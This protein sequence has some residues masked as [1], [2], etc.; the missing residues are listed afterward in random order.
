MNIFT[1]ES[2]AKSYDAYYK[3]EQGKKVDKIEKSMLLAHLR[4]IPVHPMLEIGCGTG[5]WTRFFAEHGFEVLAT[6]ISKAMLKIAEQ[7]KPKNVT[8]HKANAE[9]LPFDDHTFS[10]L[11]TIT[12]LEFV[13]DKQKALEEI[14]RVLKP[15]GWLLL[16]SLNALSELGKNKNNDEVFRHGSFFT[17]E[18]L[19]TEL[20]RFGTP[21][22]TYGVH[23]S[24]S[25][26]ILDDTNQ[27]YSYEP[28]F[29]AA[30]VQ[31]V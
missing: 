12:L 8:F 11:A 30:S 13:D 28:A 16:G 21:E 3:T 6:D 14:Y 25:F 27:K 17:P 26:E 2:V 9:D 19:K 5:H 24:P 15:N 10:V 20:S 22:I 1:D 7:K 31:K 18:E 29:M 23:F 4:K